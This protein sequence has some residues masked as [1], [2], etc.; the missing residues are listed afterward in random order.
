MLEQDRM[1]FAQMVAALDVLFGKESSKVKAQLYWEAM[2]DIPI[3]VVR[4]GYEKARTTVDRYPTVA[5]WRQCCELAARDSDSRRA[6]E[7]RGRLLELR[8]KGPAVNENTGEIYEPVYNCGVCEDRGWAY[9]EVQSGRPLQFH[10]TIGKAQ[11]ERFVKRCTCGHFKN[12]TSR[13][14]YAKITE[15]RPWQTG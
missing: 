9:F 1:Q 11:D 12:Q 5:K 10:E 7:L 8:A 13:P 4:L 15:D 14:A 6:A 3:E 2:Q